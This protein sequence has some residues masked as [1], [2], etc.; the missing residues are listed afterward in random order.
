MQCDR[1]RELIG[2]Y[3]DE[4]L[5]GAD[6]SAVSEHVRSC[7]QCREH[8]DAS[9][10][11][12]R[13]VAIAAQVEL[14]GELERNVRMS[15]SNEIKTEAAV[16]RAEVTSPNAALLRPLIRQ[17]AAIAAAC[18]LSASV[19]WL[20]LTASAATGR[21]ER[22]VVTA[23]IRSLLQDS[24]IQVASSDQHTVKPW[25]A[26]RVDFSPE[27]KDL[28]P[29]GF[30]LS[31]A[32]LDYIGDRRV[33]ALVYRRRLHV[34]NVFIWPASGPDPS[35]LRTSSIKGYNVA[36]WSKGG[37]TYWAISDLNSGELQQ[38]QSLM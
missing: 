36:S 15:L 14:P 4:E 19:T 31:G 20:A 35:P 18:I 8:A 37:V 33:G 29:E 2:A 7:A 26:G 38:L 13:Q 16:A 10:R 22:D 17:A 5:S 34:V 6:R 21:L 30:P 9:A 23:H 24:P 1:A 28:T 3:L 32:R 27:V 11:L 12:S 25:F